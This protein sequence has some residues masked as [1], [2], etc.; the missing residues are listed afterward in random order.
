MKQLKL[1]NGC[2]YLINDVSFTSCLNGSA[3]RKHVMME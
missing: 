2:L 1:L 3:S